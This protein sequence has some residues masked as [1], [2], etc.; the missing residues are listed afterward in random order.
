MPPPLECTLAKLDLVRFSLQASPAPE[1][2][3]QIEIAELSGWQKLSQNFFNRNAR[4]NS[5]P[6]AARRKLKPAAQ[7]NV[8]MPRRKDVRHDS[9]PDLF[10]CGRLDPGAGWSAQGRSGRRACRR[11]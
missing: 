2:D 3:I 11:N 10:R 8:M 1:R 6:S 4:L 5:P 9:K 7:T